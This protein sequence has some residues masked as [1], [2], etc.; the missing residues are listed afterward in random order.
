MAIFKKDHR[1][2]IDTLVNGLFRLEYRGC[3]SVGLAVDGDKKNEVFIFK[4]VARLLS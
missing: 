4:E 2:I 3:D 1:Y